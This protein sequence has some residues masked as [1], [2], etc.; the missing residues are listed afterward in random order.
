MQPSAPS[1]AEWPLVTSSILRHA[2]LHHGLQSV[3]SV[4]SDGATSVLSLWTVYE[5]C[6]RLARALERLGCRAGDVV[7]TCAWNTHRHL[8]AWHTVQ[9]SAMICHTLN[10]RL[11]DD[12]LAF[13]C[14]EASDAWLL[15]DAD[16]VPLAERLVPHVKSI[17][18]VIV[19]CGAPTAI[20]CAVQQRDTDTCASLTHQ[21]GRTCRSAP[22]CRACCV[23]RS[24]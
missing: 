4:D 17:R 16:L 9:A 22:R 2:A 7:A 11:F 24:C 10:P 23:M 21:T 18:G 5:R 12:Q 19:L 20:V 1:A 14:N 6:I 8:E 3:V 15:V 13:I